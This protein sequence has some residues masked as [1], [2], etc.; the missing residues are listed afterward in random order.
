MDKDGGLAEHE[1][2]QQER[3]ADHE[4]RRARVES[5]APVTEEPV[6]EAKEEKVEEKPKA[7]PRA[8]SRAKKSK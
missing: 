6:E 1:R 3:A 2:Q 4:E 7:Q 5:R 8:R